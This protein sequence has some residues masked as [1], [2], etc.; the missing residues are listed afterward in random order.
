LAVTA[1]VWF[2]ICD[3]W[4]ASVAATSSDTRLLTSMT[5]PPAAP[6]LVLLAIETGVVSGV[7]V[8]LPVLLVLIAFVP[9]NGGGPAPYDAGPPSMG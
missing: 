5:E 7:A 8:V 6:E 3:C 1:L 2:A 4:G 9:L